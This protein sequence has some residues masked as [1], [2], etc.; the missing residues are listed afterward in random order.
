MENGQYNENWRHIHTLPSQLPQAITELGARRVLTYH[1]SKYALA[2]HPWNEPLD[3]IW[4]RAQGH[5]WQLLTPRMGEVVHLSLD[6][7]FG[8]WW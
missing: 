5:P 4:E 6:E 3:S 8:K 2:R 1:N 7:T